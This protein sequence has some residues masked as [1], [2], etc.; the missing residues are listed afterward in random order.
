M[1]AAKSKL[2]VRRNGFSLMELLTVIAVMSILAALG[3]SAIKGNGQLDAGGNRVV[4]LINQARQ[5]SI[6][7][8]VMTALILV[9]ST[10]N[11]TIDNRLWVI[12]DYEN[13]AGTWQWQQV[14]KWEL[15]PGGVVVDSSAATYADGTTQNF[16]SYF[17][18]ANMPKPTQAPTAISYQGTSITPGT[19]V[20]FLPGGRIY[21]PTLPPPVFRVTNGSVNSGAV[22]YTNMSAGKPAN[23]YDVT[24]NVYTGLPKV[25]R[26]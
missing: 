15:L 18:S 2:T 24:I 20:V 6:S 1:H 5:N 14:S 23:Y 13:V 25:D 22:A 7:K 8:G 17:S 9:T 16:A 21:D 3:L 26:P 11:S 19:Y 4:D 12:M 10:N